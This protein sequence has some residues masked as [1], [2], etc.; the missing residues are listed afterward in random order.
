MGGIR[1]GP[2]SGQKRTFQNV[3]ENQFFA[4]FDK[5]AKMKEHHKGSSE[6]QFSPK[7]DAFRVSYGYLEF[8]FS[9]FFLRK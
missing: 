7:K 8:V 1:K 4:N 3:E 5:N 6:N 9:L 2:K